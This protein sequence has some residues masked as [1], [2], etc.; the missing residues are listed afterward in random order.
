MATGDDESDIRW[1]KEPGQPT[2]YYD[3]R[4]DGYVVPIFLGSHRELVAYQLGVDPE[5]LPPVPDSTCSEHIRRHGQHLLAIFPNASERDPIKLCKKLRRL[6]K[7][8]HHLALRNCNG[9]FVSEEECEAA[10]EKVAAKVASVLYPKGD[11]GCPAFFINRDPR[12]YALKICN[13]TMQERY[14]SSPLERDWGGH[15][16]IAPEITS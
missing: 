2:G 11:D 5:S 16:I 15:G 12:G 1:S 14:A 7:E 8:A 4:S 3:H 10:F 9:D 13:K 6:E